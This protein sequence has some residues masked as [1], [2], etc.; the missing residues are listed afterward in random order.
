VN[1]FH[2]ITGVLRSGSTLLCNV[3]NQNPAFYA[4]STS[5]ITELLGAFTHQCS[6]SPEVQAWLAD[7]SDGVTDRLTRMARSML[8]EWY[9]HKGG[10]VFD[11][12]RGWSFQALLLDQIFPDAKIIVCVREL[13]S[14]FGSVEKNHRKNP[15]FDGA[16]SPVEKTLFDRADKMMSPEGQ[17]GQSV[18]GIQDLMS[19]GSDRVYVLQHESFTMDPRTKMM[20]IY[21]FLGEP[22]FEHALDDV[23][24]VSTDLDALYLN[25]F[26]HEG[27][28][29]I[30]KSNRD[31]WKNY[32]PSDLG[33][34][35][36]ARYP[37][38]N[39]TF[40]Y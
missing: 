27:S 17:I 39:S 13:R 37:K 11:K 30:E 22:Y 28:G 23:E 32:L 34:L 19:R 35:I 2:A 18:L 31:E 12:S 29:K 6:N 36:Y 9:A 1:K 5:P 10:T 26:P 38:Y 4:S 25:K 21:E 15:V 20:E 8:E 7:D 40:G 24:N 3:L 14:V 33:D 16:N